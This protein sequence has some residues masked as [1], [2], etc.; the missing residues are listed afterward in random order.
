MNEI[1]V[2]RIELRVLESLDV[3][4]RLDTGASLF[5]TKDVYVNIPSRV[6]EDLLL[7][8]PSLTPEQHLTGTG[9]SG[10]S[11]RLPVFRLHAL[12]AGESTIDRPF[13]IVQPRAG[14]FA[15]PDAVG[16]VGNNFLE[17]FGTVT[18]DYAGRRLVLGTR[19]EPR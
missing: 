8:D 7:A 13:V 4:L 9:A 11:V 3:D 17:K 10:E 5:D 2:T 1:S 6:W 18:I 14:Y 19:P 16:F 12:L 15:R